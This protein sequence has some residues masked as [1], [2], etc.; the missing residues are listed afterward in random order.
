LPAANVIDDVTKSLTRANDVTSACQ[1]TVDAFGRHTPALAAVMLRVHDHLRCVAATGSWHM[2][3]AVPLGAGVS[4]RAYAN[5][6]TAVVTDVDN[7]SAYVPLGPPVAVEICA[8]IPGPDGPLGALNL[9]WTEP[10]D[11][12]HW[13]AVVEKI[14]AI[15]GQRLTELG[16]PPAE[17]ASE[18]VL[19]HCLAVASAPTPDELKARSLR[20][21]RELSGLSTAVLALHTPST[22]GVHVDET[23]LTP[24]GNYAAKLTPAQLASMVAQAHRYGASFTLGDPDSFDSHGF[25]DLVA[26]GARTFVAIPVGS[27]P[28]DG[29]L[30]LMLDQRPFRPSSQQVSLLTLLATHAWTS[31][32]RLRTV[33][34]LRERAS[35]DPLT[36]LR[37][38]GPFGERLTSATPGSTALLAIDLDSFKDVND[39]YGHQVGDQVLVKVAQV[40]SA[41]L[42]GGIDELYRIGG[43]E[44]AAVV[45]VQ[46]PE[47]AIGIAERLLV[48]A[49]G[50]GRT[51]SVG[52][53]IQRDGEDAQETLRRADEALY[54]AKR[55]GRDTVRMAH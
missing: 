47:E 54:V 41:T 31:L 38:H 26:A 23:E 12:P 28:V 40:L 8:P 50:T 53:A 49:R 27:S 7:D 18:Q 14:A 1:M 39:T 44:F 6:E 21:A 48:A 20:A 30:L 43:D 36:G 11:I 29:G 2:F 19:R 45:E 5:N 3:S 55:A 32:D 25:D 52:V 15:L 16:G 22:F 24:L 17:S 42:R 13:Q 9:E 34:K 4:G 35:S 33:R 37:H 46:R 10:I 51:I